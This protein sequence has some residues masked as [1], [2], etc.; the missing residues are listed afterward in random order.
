MMR[1]T[2]HLAYL[3]CRRAGVQKSKSAV[4]IP[5]LNARP[6]PGTQQSPTRLPQLDGA[7]PT[8][9]RPNRGKLMR[10]NRRRL[11]ICVWPPVAALRARS[12]RSCL[13]SENVAA[14]RVDAM[15]YLV[16]VLGALFAFDVSPARADL[17]LGVVDSATMVMGPN[18]GGGDNIFFKLTGT[19]L[20]IDG[21]GGMACFDWCS[22]GPIPPGIPIS[23]SR[24]FISNFTSAVVG[25]VAY[26]P[27]S[28]IGLSHS[29]S[30]F[31]DAGG[32]SESATGFVGQGPTFN[33]FSIS[34]P[35]DGSWTLNFIP[36]TDML[37]NDTRDFVNGTFVA[38]TATP[39]PTPEPGT[40][41]L[42]LLGSAAGWATARRRRSSISN[43][44]S[45]GN[46]A[47]GVVA[48]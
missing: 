30:F 35:Q 34:L 41:A 12:M 43:G 9:R 44:S 3:R 48:C 10:D 1:W 45:R 23:L 24:V 46:S 7:R 38:G 26:D 47:S 31:D 29:S 15:R 8:H 20:E 42:M 37:G 4:G 27:N 32:L 19:G 5:M 16:L 6:P 22:G 39:T 2:Q 36:D 13:T 40:L 11:L 17:I 21:I 28:E 14:E 33:E 25:G 18:F